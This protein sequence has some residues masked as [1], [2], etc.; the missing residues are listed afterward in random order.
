LAFQ[1]QEKSGSELP[2]S[3]PMASAYSDHGQR[4]RDILRI[5]ISTHVRYCKYSVIT[6]NHCVYIYILFLNIIQFFTTTAQLL[7][8]M[9]VKSGLRPAA[10]AES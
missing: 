2:T 1:G 10:A 6:E 4:K 3:K 8:S 9:I 7:I 5:T